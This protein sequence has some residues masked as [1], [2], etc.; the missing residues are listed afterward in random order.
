LSK[1]QAASTHARF[2]SYFE[3]WTTVAVAGRMDSACGDRQ[4]EALRNASVHD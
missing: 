1:F 4:R 3:G 2:N